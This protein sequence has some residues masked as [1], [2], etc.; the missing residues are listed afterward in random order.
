MSST[1]HL[2]FLTPGFAA[3]EE[4]SVCTPYLQAYFSALREARPHWRLSIVAMQYPYAAGRYLWR[5]MEVWAMGGRNRKGAKPWVWR[6]TVRAVRAL[7]RVQPIHLIHSFWLTEA[8]LLAARCATRLGVPHFA[9]C[10]G[11]DALPGN[12]YLGRLPLGRM[13]L[14]AVSADNAAQFRSSTGLDVEA[15]IPW[16]IAT[17]DL[18]PAA[19]ADRPVDLLAAGS[20]APVKRYDRLVRVVAMLRDEFPTL[21][22]VLVGDGPER[23]A[24]ERQAGE[25]GLEGHLRFAGLLGRPAVLQAMSQAKVFLHSSQSEGAGLVLVEALARGCHLVTT[26]VGLGASLP[27]GIA[28]D[29]CAVTASTFGLYAAARAFLHS[30]VDWLPRAPFPL[31]QTLA[32]HLA[33]YGE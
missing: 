3:N 22:A 16:G 9:S 23:G 32:G 17:E 31:S 1:R 28:A 13:R 25:L 30:P 19:L 7:H 6:Q 14:I 27:Q 8:A 33:L 20:L 5:G 10:M 18:D 21:N 2:V 24:L 11:Q 26:P 15:V 29:K 4:D 12:R